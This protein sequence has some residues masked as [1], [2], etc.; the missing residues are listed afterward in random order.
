MKHQYDGNTVD[1]DPK[2]TSQLRDLRAYLMSNK[3]VLDH[4]Q[5]NV[6]VDIVQS[7]GNNNADSLVLRKIRPKFRQW[8]KSLLNIGSGLAQGK[9]F[10]DIFEDVL[11]Q[12]TFSILDMKLNQFEAA[13]LFEVTRD[14]I[15]RMLPK[16]SEAWI[17]YVYV[18]MRIA[19]IGMERST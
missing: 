18:T 13:T 8:L 2:F 16:Y 10:R 19:L 5:R 6:M 15:S 12:L 9:E 14:E 11:V 17:A 7:I 3:S 1:L 4:V